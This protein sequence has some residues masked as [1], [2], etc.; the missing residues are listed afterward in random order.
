MGKAYIILVII[1]MLSLIF[2]SPM[3]K[4]VIGEF[5]VARFLKRLDKEK[6]HVFN[7]LYIPK[8]DGTTSQIDHL[9]ISVYGIF[10]I[11]TKN[12]GGWIFGDEK[13]HN[14]TQTIYRRKNRFPNPIIQNKGHIKYLSQYLEIK[15]LDLFKPIIVFTS[16]V[17]FKKINTT[18][19]VIYT[20]HLPKK[21]KS[22][23]QELLSVDKVKEIS[24]QIKSIGKADR[25]LKK[26]H[27]EQ[28]KETV[29]KQAKI[30]PKCGQ[31][32]VKRKG[33]QGEFIGCKGFP[34][35]RY[36]KMIE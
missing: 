31:E 9:I 21:I 15:T 30:C 27:V 19:P 7:D 20:I 29:E 10:V 4:G 26:K 5:V 32:L 34:K 1:I 11:E 17:T 6:Y 2:N 22:Y 33:K 13:Q 16:R 25:Q 12:Y 23:Q 24:E 35:C 36:T 18:T 8:K 3:V 14:W 28:V